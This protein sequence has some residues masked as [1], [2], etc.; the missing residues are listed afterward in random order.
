MILARGGSKSIPLKNLQKI[1]N[2]SLIQISLDIIKTANIF[3]S[4]WVSTDHE[5]IAQESIKRNKIKLIYVFI[6]CLKGL[7]IVDDVNVHIRPAN[8]STDEASSLL[9]VQEFLHKHKEIRLVALIQCTSPFMQKNYLMRAF[10]CFHNN[11]CDCAFA[12]TRWVF[13]KE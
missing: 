10:N 12:V 2:K 7:F 8:V 9:A 4:I 13:I 3:D 5:I 6:N 1:G 11:D